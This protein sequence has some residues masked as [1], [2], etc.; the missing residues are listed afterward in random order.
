MNRRDFLATAATAGAF[1]ALDPAYLAAKEGLASGKAADKPVPK[2][3]YGRTKDEISVIGFGGIVVMDVTPAEAANHVAEAVDRGV[4]YFDVAPTYGN[5]QERLGPALK[6]HRQKCFL[7]C[8]TTQRDAAGA[9]KELEESLRLLQADHI[10]LCQL[11]ALTKVEEVQQVFAPGGAMETF[12]K[13]RKDGKVRYLGFSAHSEEAG[14]AALDKFDFDSI[15]FPLGFP[16]W[17]QGKFGPSIHKRAKEAGKGI[18]ALKAMACQKWPEGDRRWKKAWYKPFD[19][20]DQVHDGPR[21]GPIGSAHAAQ[22]ER[23]EDHQGDCPEVGPHLWPTQMNGN[24][25]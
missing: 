10:D 8:K 9:A 15:L 21:T 7:A 13:A 4:N 1:S 2:R 17:I 3:Q 5:A 19:Q 16:T 12:V 11:H 20:I 6:P 24:A 14:L 25:P 22:R 23:A 18:L